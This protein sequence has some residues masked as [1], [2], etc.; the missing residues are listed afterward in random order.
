MSTNTH[1][2]IRK[3]RK[4]VGPRLE[5]FD[6]NKLPRNVR[7][8]HP[9]LPL[10]LV[11]ETYVFEGIVVWVMSFGQEHKWVYDYTGEQARLLG[12]W[13][14]VRTQI[15]QETEEVIQ[16]E[17]EVVQENK[18]EVQEENEEVAQEKEEE[19]E[20]VGTV[21][22]IKKRKM[23]DE[24]EVKY[25]GTVKAPRANDDEEDE[26]EFDDDATTVSYDVDEGDEEEEEEEGDEVE[27]L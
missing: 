4:Y 3:I 11:G 15:F 22:P 20:F 10:G 6:L 1:R 14:P 7:S 8:A 13:D 16:E 9:S 17:E 18:E 27:I 26:E 19:V 23:E 24:E 25:L 5:W 12:M 2:I 21:P